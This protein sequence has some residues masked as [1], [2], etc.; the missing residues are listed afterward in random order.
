MFHV[1]RDW[2]IRLSLILLCT[3][4]CCVGIGY[5]LAG[6]S[7]T[8]RTQTH[9]A[10]S[11]V[12]VLAEIGRVP[13]IVSRE[14][15]PCLNLTDPTCW[16][17]LVTF[18]IQSA[19]HW[20]GQSLV[21][22][23]QPITDW[24]S[25]NPNNVV[26]FTPPDLTY[27]NTSVKLLYSWSVGV[28]DTALAVFLALAGYNIMRGATRHYE[29]MQTIPTLLL[30]AVAA[31]FSL[32]L[33][34]FIIDINNALCD[35]IRQ[36]ATVSIVTDLF[37]HLFTADILDAGL[38]TFLLAL[39]FGVMLFL[40]VLSMLVR[41]AI[42][43]LYIAFAPIWVLCWGLHQTERWARSCTVG[44]FSAVFVQAIQVGALGLGGMLIESFSQVSVSIVVIAKLGVGIAIM[45][46]VLRLPSMLGVTM[47][48]PLSEASQLS[49]RMGQQ[50]ISNVGQAAARVAAL[51]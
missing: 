11:I 25:H 31:N 37:A 21:T 9:R 41:L 22:A 3:G 36:I 32:V 46:V 2:K 1:L 43:D 44:F 8:Q 51:L 50:V 48:R 28:A 13:P 29:S 39:T 49:V 20:I 18:L 15:A 47:L 42:I 19:A 5:M 27:S 38:L 12:P 16:Q 14:A 33:I 4:I 7:P 23:F 24:I 6:P 40:L 17:S 30:A 35:G 45:Y 34:P 26:T 10:L